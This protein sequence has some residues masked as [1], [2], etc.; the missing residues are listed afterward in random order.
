MIRRRPPLRVFSRFAQRC[1]CRRGNQVDAAK[2]RAFAAVVCSPLSLHSY[3]AALN[4][5]SPE[6]VLCGPRAV[7]LWL[8]RLGRAWRG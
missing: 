5:R 6:A 8:A 7:S 2:R 1:Q 3:S 4:L